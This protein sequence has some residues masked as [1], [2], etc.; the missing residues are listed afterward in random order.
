MN[1]VIKLASSHQPVFAT[2]Y[3]VA[4]G[5][6]APVAHPEIVN[7]IIARFLA[8]SAVYLGVNRDARRDVHAGNDP[9]RNER[10]AQTA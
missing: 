7:P 1:D 9:K 10:I 6:T 5:H 4:A 3:G 2:S 8:D